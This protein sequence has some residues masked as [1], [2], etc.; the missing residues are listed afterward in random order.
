MTLQEYLDRAQVYSKLKSDRGIARAL[1]ISSTTVSFYR[2]SRAIPSQEKMIE[3]ADLAGIGREEALLDWMEFHAVGNHVKSSID[4]IRIKAG[5]AAASLLLIFGLSMAG[6]VV[7]S[8]SAKV[9]TNSYYGKYE[10]S[11]RLTC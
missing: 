8:A 10:L 6:Q 3:L 1:G 4:I 2:R 7:N 5:Y 11:Q 9:A